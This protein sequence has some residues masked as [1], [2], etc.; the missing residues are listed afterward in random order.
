[1]SRINTQLGQLAWPAV[2]LVTAFIAVFVIT[3][4]VASE[5]RSV[6]QGPADAQRRPV[7]PAPQTSAQQ[8][9]TPQMRPQTTPQ[10]SPQAPITQ[11]AP[12]RTASATWQ[13]GVLVVT[14]AAA[15]STPPP[16]GQPSGQISI[17]LPVLEQRGDSMCLIGPWHPDR[18]GMGSGWQHQ[19][20]GGW[21]RRYEAGEPLYLRP[22]P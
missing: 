4:F 18:T 11:T 20:E 9:P 12:A 2:A 7:P 3:K 6:Q 15:V 10:T 13:R 1:M 21:C 17:T 19:V 16:G 8:T 5:P 22:G 14:V